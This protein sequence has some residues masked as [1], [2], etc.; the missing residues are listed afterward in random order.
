M[1]DWLAA[2][3]HALMY[4]PGAKQG[5]FPRRLRSAFIAVTCA[6]EYVRIALLHSKTNFVCNNKI[7]L[8]HITFPDQ[9]KSRS[10]NGILAGTFCDLPLLV[11]RIHYQGNACQPS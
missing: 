3:A 5:I 7:L 2:A 8:H 1:E 10:Y 11:L 4:C 6:E 9:Y